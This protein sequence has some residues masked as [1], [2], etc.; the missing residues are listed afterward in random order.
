LNSSSVVHLLGLR[1]RLRQSKAEWISLR[2]S[3]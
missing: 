1:F 3:A 2:E